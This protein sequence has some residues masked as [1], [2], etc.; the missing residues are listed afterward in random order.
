MIRTTAD[1]IRELQAFPP[2]YAVVLGGGE[3]LLSVRDHENLRLVSLDSE[4]AP[5]GEEQAVQDALMAY[6]TEVTT[7]LRRYG[8][9]EDNKRVSA[10]R[11][12]Y[13]G[14]VREQVRREGRP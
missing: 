13:E 5:A 8:T 10:A 2:D 14:L 11:A 4:P 12:E 9:C 7:A 1:L 3:D 6:H